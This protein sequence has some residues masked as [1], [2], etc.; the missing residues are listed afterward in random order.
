MSKR[1]SSYF[2]TNQELRQLTCKAAQLKVLQELYE[3]LAPTSLARFSYVY[4]VELQT[5]ILAASNS[6][7]AAKLRQLAPQLAGQ[8]RYAGQ[9]VTRIQVRVQV[10]S[11]PVG[12]VSAV[13]ALSAD[14][15][16]KLVELAGNLPD[17]P[18]KKA[19]QKLAEKE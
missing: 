11:H 19:L 12:C 14:G 13:R 3:Q 18:L 9:E 15:R 5:L 6:A 7:I 17:S 10:G 2:N 16:Q 4:S 1:L 8:F